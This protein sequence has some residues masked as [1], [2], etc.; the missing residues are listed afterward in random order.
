MTFFRSHRVPLLTAA[1]SFA[2]LCDDGQLVSLV[3]GKHY[4]RASDTCIHMDGELFIHIRDLKIGT[5]S[6]RCFIAADDG[7]CS[8]FQQEAN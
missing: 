8:P 1:K 5:T 6:K 3:L 7:L 4:P 2:E